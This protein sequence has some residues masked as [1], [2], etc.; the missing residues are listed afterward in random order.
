MLT[1]V[2]ATQGPHLC[3]RAALGSGSC[4]VKMSVVCGPGALLHRT[5][6]WDRGGHSVTA[7]CSR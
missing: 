2:R 3:H 7:V 4:P 6:Q 5:A 1:Q